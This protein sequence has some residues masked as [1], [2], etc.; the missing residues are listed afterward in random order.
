M[1]PAAQDKQAR[2]SLLVENLRGMLTSG[3][4]VGSPATAMKLA[5]SL[6]TLEK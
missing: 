4:L 6:R 2:N 1:S 3:E 5:K